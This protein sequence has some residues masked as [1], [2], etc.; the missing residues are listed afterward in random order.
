MA[1]VLLFALVFATIIDV[2]VVIAAGVVLL[3]IAE[4]AVDVISTFAI[5][6]AVVALRLELL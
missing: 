4:F 1:E 5:V 2:A 3:V 6:V